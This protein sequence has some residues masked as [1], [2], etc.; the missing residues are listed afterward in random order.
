MP[1]QRPAPELD[2]EWLV[3]QIAHALRNPIFAALV[4]VDALSLRTGQ[5]PEARRAIET[6]QRQLRRLEETIND[7]LLFG[8]R[9][10]LKRTAVDVDELVTTVADVYR[11]GERQEPAAVTVRP[12]GSGLSASWDPAAVRSILERLLDNAVQHSKPPHRVEL[13]VEPDA[14]GRVTLAVRDEGE[15]IPHELRDRVMLPFFPQH[16]GRPGLGLAIAMKL[17]EQLGGTL[18]LESQ[19]GVGTEVRVCLPRETPAG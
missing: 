17:T 9:V 6:L 10:Q 3:N 12:A 15:G 2:S 1:G 11:R 8:R 19:P 14:E 13:R 7:M 18:T 5:Q 16:R 4:Q